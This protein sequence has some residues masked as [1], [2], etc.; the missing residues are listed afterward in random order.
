MKEFSFSDTYLAVPGLGC[1][2][3]IFSHGMR[4]LRCGPWDLVPL[5]G[6][7]SRPPPLGGQCESTRGQRRC[8]PLKPLC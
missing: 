1:S 6:I 5:L 4:T 7:K 2:S 8:A 3:G